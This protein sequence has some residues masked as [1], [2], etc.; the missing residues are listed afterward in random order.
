MVQAAHGFGF[1]GDI[2]FKMRILHA[3]LERY[4]FDGI[5]IMGGCEFGG[6]YDMPE[7]PFTHPP[8]R[9]KMTFFQY[10]STLLFRVRSKHSSLFTISC[11]NFIK[12]KLSA[13]FK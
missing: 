13:D 1:L 2:A 11:S 3:F 9:L 4:A 5:K 8:Y 12:E 6:Q 7:A 10:F